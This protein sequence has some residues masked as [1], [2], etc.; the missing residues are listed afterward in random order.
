[1][2]NEKVQHHHGTMS[3]VNKLSDA[4]HNDFAVGF[5]INTTLASVIVVDAFYVLIAKWIYYCV[6]TY[7]DP[8]LTELSS[9]WLSI[10]SSSSVLP[11][12]HQNQEYT[13]IILI[14]PIIASYVLG[15]T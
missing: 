13:E 9:I 10:A 7:T 2:N 11:M 12:S 3:T 1:M 6:Y 15:L 4:V 5:K 8:E 14:T